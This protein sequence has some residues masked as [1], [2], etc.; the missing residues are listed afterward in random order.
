MGRKGKNGA[1]AEGL[2]W[3]R[4]VA[5]I[6]LGAFAV[7]VLLGLSSYRPRAVAHNWAGPV[8]QGV[9]GA[10]LDLA[11][12]GGYALAL[13]LCAVACALVAGWPRLSFA[14][15]GSW[16]LFSVCAMGLVDLFVHA[17]L[18]GHAPGGA[19]GRCWRLRPIRRSRWRAR[20]CCSAPSPRQRW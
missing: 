14:R 9:A 12:V 16:L 19:L 5:G 13:F 1:Q 6:L 18:Q 17:R 10:L 8:G 4:P 7:V 3:K 11:G 2:R 15:A 20:R